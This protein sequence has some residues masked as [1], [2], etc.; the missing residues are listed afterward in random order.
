MAN[1][2]TKLGDVLDALMDVDAA[3][4][5]Q[6]RRHAQAAEDACQATAGRSEP[7]PADPEG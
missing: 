1:D 7:D 4:Q 2:W 5:A 6:E 3:H